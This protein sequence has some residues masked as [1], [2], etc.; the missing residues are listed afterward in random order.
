MKFDEQSNL[1]KCFL[2]AREG[3][4]SMEGTYMVNCMNTNPYN[5]THKVKVTQCGCDDARDSDEKYKI[6]SMVEH[7]NYELVSPSKMYMLEN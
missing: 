4:W 1:V 3:Y 6:T 7:H 2:C 5:K